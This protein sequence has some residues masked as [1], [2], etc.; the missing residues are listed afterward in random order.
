MRRK[1]HLLQS[2]EKS[3]Q[4][5]WYVRFRC[6]A[7]RFR[8]RAEWPAATA[9]GGGV[10]HTDVHAEA[11]SQCAVATLRVSRSRFS[12]LAAQSFEGFVRIEQQPYGTI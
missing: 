7:G 1:R 9:L 5:I 11:K 12:D 10:S 2:A 6:G 4:R 3:I 8:R